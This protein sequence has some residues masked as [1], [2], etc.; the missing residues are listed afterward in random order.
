MDNLLQLFMPNLFH[1]DCECI[2]KTKN[3]DLIGTGVLVIVSIIIACHYAIQHKKNFSNPYFQEK[4]ISI[5]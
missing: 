4:I 2:N 3:Y 1:C 5:F